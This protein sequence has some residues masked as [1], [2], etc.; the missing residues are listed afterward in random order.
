MCVVLAVLSGCNQ[1]GK[2]EI[3]QVHAKWEQAYLNR[4]GKEFY[5]LL[6]LPSQD[7]YSLI[8]SY[9]RNANRMQIEQ[10]PA[11][12]RFQ[13]LLLRQMLTGEQMAELNGKSYVILTIDEGWFD[14]DYAWT[15][16]IRDIKFSSE[17]YASAEIVLEGG[18]AGSGDTHEG[19]SSHNLNM[20]PRFFTEI[21]EFGVVPGRLTGAWLHL[22]RVALVEPS[23]LA[24]K[25]LLNS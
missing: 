16:T 18:F 11:I 23:L 1:E 2:Q 9:A 20:E 5:E 22:A 17:N 12:E 21:A 4:D 13:I 8:L 6:A 19:M 14:P 25:R 15:E 7:Y 24:A 3:K 10:S